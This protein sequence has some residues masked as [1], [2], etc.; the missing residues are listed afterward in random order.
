M[1][2]KI[3][4]KIDDSLAGGWKMSKK[5]SSGGF[6]SSPT[7][8]NRTVYNREDLWRLSSEG[9]SLEE[10]EGNLVLNILLKL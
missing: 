7:Y 5:I 4:E 1:R 10:D 2:K 8:D 9:F 6:I 3:Q